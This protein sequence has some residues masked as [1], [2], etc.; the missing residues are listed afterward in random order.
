MQPKL[1]VD[2]LSTK[3]ERRLTLTSTEIAPPSPAQERK[4]VVTLSNKLSAAAAEKSAEKVSF[5]QKSK[6]P[7]VTHP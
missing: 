4:N 7:L 1:Q 2:R 5:S 6:Y 3:F